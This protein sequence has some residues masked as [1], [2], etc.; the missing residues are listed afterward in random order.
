MDE[1]LLK[2]CKKEQTKFIKPLD[3]FKMLT[4]KKYEYP[5]DVQSQIWEKWFDVRDKKNNIIK[6]NTG[7]GKTVVGLV[8]LQSCLNEGCFP[9]VYIVPDRYLA[10]QVKTEADNL[11]IKV[12]DN[13]NDYAFLNGKSILITNVHKVFNAKSVFGMR[14]EKYS[15]ISIGSVIVDDVHTCLEIIKNKYTISI[16]KNHKAYKDVFDLVKDELKMYY[17]TDYIDIVEYND[18]RK[19]MIVPFWFWQNKKDK[20]YSVLKKI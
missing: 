19:R 16:E 12:T 10:M 11:G 20:I 17:S 3:V 2:L 1:I 7:S 13:E 8:I 5:R 18:P 9:A 4:E 14:D 6:M 15:N